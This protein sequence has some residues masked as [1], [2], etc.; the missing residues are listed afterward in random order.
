MNSK[1]VSMQNIADALGITKVSVS[2]ALND[3]P[4]ISRNLKKQIQS[5]ASEMGY[6][7][8]NGKLSTQKIKKLGFFIPAHFFVE[9]DKFYSQIYYYLSKECN[10]INI[11]L[12]LYIISQDDENTLSIPYSFESENL[13]GLFIVGEFS[14][15]YIINLLKFNIP[16]VTIDF[17]KPF[18]SCDSIVFDNFNSSYMATLYLIKN[19]HKNIGFVGNPN[20]TS[21]VADRYYGYLKALNQNSL[22]YK[23]EWHIISND[24]LG[25]YTDEYLLPKNLPTAFLC[26]C[27]MAAYNFMVRLRLQGIS[28]PEQVSL[29]S[30]DNTPLSQKC[31]PALTTVDNETSKLSKMAFKQMLWRIENLSSEYQKVSLSTKLIERSSVKSIEMS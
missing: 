26:H 12:T 31:N 17:Y 3:Q 2:K 21:S 18:F 4:G 11:S 20:Y 27:D 30:F 8:G 16:T 19:G 28:V 23:K 13:D 24:L 14:D 5:V 10:R 7:K 25:T 9:S 1:N 6:I 22:E 15:G 29:I